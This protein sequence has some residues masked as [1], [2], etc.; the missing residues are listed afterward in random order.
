M[1]L[2]AAASAPLVCF[3]MSSNRPTDVQVMLLCVPSSWAL[4]GVC[5]LLSAS[6]TRAPIQLLLSP[7]IKTVPCGLQTCV[8]GFRHT[9]SSSRSSSA[10]KWP[11]LP[12]PSVILFRL[13]ANPIRSC[14]ETAALHAA[15]YIS[16]RRLTCP[17]RDSL[18][19]SLPWR[20][21]HAHAFRALLV[22]EHPT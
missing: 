20:P 18:G 7:L 14:R 10:C 1:P 9:N 6:Q 11:L 2:W 13:S 3:L 16:C 8:A 4:Y 21:T 12:P 5:L 15:N 19:S 22:C 17:L